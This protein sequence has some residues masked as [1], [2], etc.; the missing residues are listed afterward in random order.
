MDKS[1]LINIVGWIFVCTGVLDAVKYGIQS[2]KIKRLGTSKGM[3]R[4]FLNIAISNDIIK[5]TYGILIFDFYVTITSLIALFTMCEM[6]WTVYQLY[7]Y[8]YRNL[9]NF[10]KPSIFIYIVNSLLPNATR[11]HL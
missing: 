1:I 8:R 2:S 6:W 5:L 11:K 4:Q 10:K 9:K 7:P 3:S